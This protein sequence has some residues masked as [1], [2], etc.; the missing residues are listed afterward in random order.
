MTSPTKKI[1]QRLH[2]WHEEGSL[3][4]ATPK[5]VKPVTAAKRSHLFSSNLFLEVNAEARA[6]F[7]GVTKPLACL[8][9][10]GV[11]HLKVHGVYQPD[12]WFRH[13]TGVIINKYVT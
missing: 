8:Q 5:E 6:S 1:G 2:E 9:E 10:Y 12:S 13:V 4:W 7:N 3:T 11:T